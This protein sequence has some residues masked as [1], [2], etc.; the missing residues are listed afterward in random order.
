[1]FKFLIYVFLRDEVDLLWSFRSTCIQTQQRGWVCG[2]GLSQGPCEVCQR[3]TKNN[4]KT[5]IY[6]Y[7]YIY[8]FS[9]FT[10]NF[11]DF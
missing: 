1:M 3:K 6:I 4:N 10:S 8:I 5:N 7:I 9:S 11:N 2:L